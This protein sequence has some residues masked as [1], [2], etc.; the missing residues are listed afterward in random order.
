MKRGFLISV[1]AYLGL[2]LVLEALFPAPSYAYLDPGTGNVLVYLAISLVGTVLYFVKNIVYAIMGRAKGERRPEKQLH[3]E[4]ILMFSEGR[5]YYYTFKPV[6]DAFL[7]RGVPF[8]YI[9]MDVEDPALTIENDLMNSRYIGTGSAAF[10][11]AAGR[12]ADIMLST[13][14]NIGTPG[15]PMPRPRRV[16]N[17]AHICHGVG[18]IAMYQK[19]A[20][21]HYDA[22]LMVGDFMLPSIRKVEELRGLPPK[23]CVSLGLPYLDELAAKA[24][25]KEGRSTPPVVLVAPSWGNKGC[26]NICGPNF[27]LDLAKAGYDV[28]LRPHPQSLKVETE[29]LDTI[30]EM[31]RDY[32]NVSFDTEM[33]ATASMSR[34]DVMISDKSCVRFDFAFLYEKPVITLDIP[35]RNPELYEVAD[36]GVIWEDTVAARLG[37]VVSP[38]DFNNIVPVVERALK[39]PSSAIAAFRE[40]SVAC[41]G[42][43]GEAIAQWTVDTLARMDADDVIEC[44]DAEQI[45]RLVAEGGFDVA[46]LGYRSGD[47]YYFRER[48]LRRS[49]NFVWKGVVHEVIEPRGRVVYSSAKIVHKKLKK[50]DPLRNLFIYQRH[51]AGGMRLDGRQQFYY[52]RELFYCSMYAQAVAVLEQ[53]LRGDGWAV[54]KAEACRTLYY[55]HRALGDGD[56]A[57]S[58]LTDAFLYLPPRAQDCCLLAAELFAQKNYACARY[59]YEHALQSP[60]RAEE[61][62]FVADGYSSFIPLINLVA[63]CVALGDLPAAVRYNERAGALKPGHPSYLANAEYFKRTGALP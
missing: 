29:M 10:A 34:A 56:R 51:I 23:E 11:R 33:D 27:L 63:V 17:L 4:R 43:S 25:K 3:H 48:I 12:R 8:S 9:T 52:G 19:G 49:M 39:T 13:T 2:W 47:L 16:T 61:G 30:H 35:V 42:R 22:V 38:E 40:E 36:L 57:V 31:L 53:F 6:I 55:C 50:G 15:F 14:P 7:R 20:L 45:R 60:E 58:A 37:E 32:P 62:G 41:W 21:D 18:D 1:G 54:N 46:M 44:E 26:L 24:R 59:W 28:I 5:S